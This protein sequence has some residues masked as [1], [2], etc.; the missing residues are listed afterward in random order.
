MPADGEGVVAERGIGRVARR[1][2]AVH[3]PAFD[4][5][6]ERLVL[7]DRVHKVEFQPHLLLGTGDGK[8]FKEGLAHVPASLLLVREDDEGSRML[9]DQP[10]KL[11][12][13][14]LVVFEE[15]A[16][17]VLGKE[18][19]HLHRLRGADECGKRGCVV[20]HA[21]E[22]IVLTVLS[23]YVKGQFLS[24]EDVLGDVDIKRH[25]E[26][27]LLRDLAKLREKSPLRCQ[28]ALIHLAA[29]FCDRFDVAPV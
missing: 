28:D 14:A 12:R 16:A 15:P 20:P 21:L 8:V 24:V 19:R 9:E 6:P 17:G 26:P 18:R 23:L 2:L 10:G 5:V 25:A 29:L 27:I 22:G 3:R 4:L 13:S 7:R 1:T 11:R